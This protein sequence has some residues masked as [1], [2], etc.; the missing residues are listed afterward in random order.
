[1]AT[2]RALLVSCL[3]ASCLI[4]APAHA[5][6]TRQVD[7]GEGSSLAIDGEGNAH[8]GYR[9]G[10]ITA[11]KYATSA[12]G[13]WV[14]EIVDPDVGPADFPCSLAIDGL[15][16]AHISYSDD[17]DLV[18][19]TNE[20]GFWL[21]RTLDSSGEVWTTTSLA[22]DG[23]DHVHI[24]YSL[25][26]GPLMHVTNA[27][28]TWVTTPIY[29]PGSGIVGAPS[30]ALDG[31]D[32][33]HFSYLHMLSLTTRELVHA[34]NASGSWEYTVAGPAVLD[35][36]YNDIAVDA[37]GFAHI[38]FLNTGTDDLMYATN[39][40]GTWVAVTVDAT[41]HVVG[42]VSIVL[43]DSDKVHIS[44]RDLDSD[45]LKY[46]TNASGAWV[47]ETACDLPAGC[48]EDPSIALGPSGAVYISHHGG[49]GALLLSGPCTDGD[50]DGYG[51]PASPVC[52][53]PRADCDDADPHV[54]PG[55]AEICN[56]EGIDED[57]DGLADAADPDCGY[58]GTANTVATHHGAGSL[59]G[60]GLANGLALILAPLA[61]ILAWK[62]RG[63]RRS[64]RQ[65]CA[66][67][68]EA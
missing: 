4:C 7:V 22:L 66:M 67:N 17:R 34:T 63:R 36:S 51:D 39:A 61:V 45:A 13:E 9:D 59:T 49:D 32:N 46:A 27:S 31:S 2:R 5:W 53:H 16:K 19:A 54:N 30:M 58:S 38:G 64:P 42:G 14:T 35:A 50:G 6:V 47:T 3:L 18:Y 57:C 12:S 29:P 10:T 26:P 8:I 24:G 23:S 48:G 43:D 1:M 21:G 37:S 52:E 60:S 25:S 56:E 11:L 65:P 44:Y 40:S 20:A 15:G 41:A 55:A 62:G 33:L 28:G 68:E